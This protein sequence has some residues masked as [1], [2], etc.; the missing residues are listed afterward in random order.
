M[1]M[2]V[3]LYA[4]PLVKTDQLEDLICDKTAFNLF[5]TGLS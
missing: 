2:M 5:I 1:V 3:R 4:H